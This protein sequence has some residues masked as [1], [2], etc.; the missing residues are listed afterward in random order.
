M[1]PS[2][3]HVT[4]AS[5]MITLELDQRRN[6]QWRYRIIET[7]GNERRTF[8]DW[9]WG[10]FQAKETIKQAEERFGTFDKVYVLDWI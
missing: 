6:G 8:V 4:L 3:A 10:T 5:A 9:E 1:N 7:I 2:L